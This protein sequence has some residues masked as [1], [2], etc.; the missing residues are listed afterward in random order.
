MK[1]TQSELTWMQVIGAAQRQLDDV[2]A[3]IPASHTCR[4][5]MKEV[6]VEVARFA[7]TAPTP[8][9]AYALMTAFWFAACRHVQTGCVE[10]E[11]IVRWMG[12]EWAKYYP[13]PVIFVPAEPDDAT[14]EPPP[15]D[16]D[17]GETVH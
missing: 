4:E 16:K 13:I 3:R 1:E 11:E 14:Q 6:S 10:R 5:M 17:P 2:M 12:A 15:T 9:H 7:H 8:F